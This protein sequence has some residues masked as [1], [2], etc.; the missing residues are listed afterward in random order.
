M[1]TLSLHKRN[2]HKRYQNWL[3]LGCAQGTAMTHWAKSNKHVKRL[4][5]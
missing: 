4:T 2:K 5:S 3:P 1:T